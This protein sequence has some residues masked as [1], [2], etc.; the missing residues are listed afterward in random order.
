MNT[1]KL[2]Q[3]FKGPNLRAKNSLKKL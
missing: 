2:I 1:Q 3:F